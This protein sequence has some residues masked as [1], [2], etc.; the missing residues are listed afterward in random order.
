M[1]D[2]TGDVRAIATFLEEGFQA[3]ETDVKRIR[4]AADEIDRL[5]NLFGTRFHLDTACG[6]CGGPLDVERDGICCRCTDGRDAEIER[7]RAGLPET[8]D[9]VSVVPGMIVWTWLNNPREL[10]PIT[11][12]R[13]CLGGVYHACYS[14]REAAETARQP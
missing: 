7:L 1:S 9:G 6:S 13:V 14:T 8:A 2:L 5:H 3:T 4:S 12:T 11:I 10:E